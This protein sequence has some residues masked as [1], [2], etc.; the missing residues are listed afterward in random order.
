MIPSPSVSMTT[1]ILPLF[2]KKRHIH[3][4]LVNCLLAALFS[5]SVVYDRVDS[6][7]KSIVVSVGGTVGSSEAVR[8]LERSDPVWSV[9]RRGVVIRGRR[10]ARLSDGAGDRIVCSDFIVRFGSSVGCGC[11][12]TS[13][14]F[15]TD[16]H[17]IGGT[18]RGDW[19]HTRHQI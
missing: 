17:G 3:I 19:V 9:V 18:S 14:T 6:T 5:R 11:A 1:R 7:W 16:P 8:I 12:P 2:W 15:H 13:R 10:G 4:L